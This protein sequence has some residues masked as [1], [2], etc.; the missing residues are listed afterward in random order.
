MVTRIGAASRRLLSGGAAGDAGGA[1]AHH[2]ASN[3]AVQLVARVVSMAIS[4]VTVSLAARTL[5]PDGFG[6]WSGAMAFVGLFAVLTDLGFTTAAMQRMAAEPEREHEWLG[7]LA[8][9]RF[10]LS[11][12]AMVLCAA[13]V[14]L[15]LGSDDDVDVV[16]WILT[17]TILAT[18]ANALMA[19]FQTRLR[20]GLALSF[21]VLHSVLWLVAVVVLTVTGGDPVAFAAGYVLAIGVI[22]VLQIGVTRRHAHIAWRAGRRLWR[23]LLQVALPLGIAGVLM[24]V[25]YQ[26]DSVLLLNLAGP[27]ETG[28]YGAAY[29]FIQPLTFF[30]AAVMSSFFPV[31][32]AIRDSDPQR[33]NRL[34][35]VAADYMAVISLPI[36][37]GAIALSGP[38]V[39]VLY[40]PEYERAAGLLP[41]LMAAFVS[42]CFGTLAGFLAPLT[43]LQWRLALYSGI[44]AAA[45][46]ALN[47][48]LIPSHGAYGAAWATVITE[49]LTMVLMLGTALRRLRLRLGPGRIGRVLVV[50]AAS[51]GA[52]ALAGRLGL[53]PGVV[54]GLVTY[55]A[56]LALLRVVTLDELRRLR[57]QRAEAA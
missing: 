3:V 45:N 2:I 54:A 48:A 38:I 47:I 49:V 36:L 42:I 5:G 19:V 27:E 53:A 46:V 10:S 31:L 33:V 29:R 1:G 11:V 24:T 16:A 6:V 7:A 51:T 39:D 32:S 28:V 13:T 52:M 43:N 18:G 40:G 21:S 34:V 56:G 41:I 15:F 26:I 30:P 22:A 8:G 25:Y 20:A 17:L 9:A 50:A 55:P 44:G 57:R 12:V 14:P 37:G 35:Q 23:P 4:I